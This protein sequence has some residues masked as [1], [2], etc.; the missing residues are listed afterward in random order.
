MAGRPARQP[1][2][3]VNFIPPVRDYEFGH[4]SNTLAGRSW[5]WWETC[6]PWYASTD[7]S[8]PCRLSS[9]PIVASP[10]RHVTSTCC[11][12]C[13]LPWEVEADPGGRPADPG[14]RV[15]TLQDPVVFLLRQSSHHPHITWL[16]RA[17]LVAKL[18]RQVEAD[19]GGRPADPGTRVP[20]LQDPV[21]V[22]LRQ[23]SHH[24]HITWL[25][26]AAIVAKPNHDQ[27]WFCRGVGCTL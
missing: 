8:G 9:P 26:R 2:A 4:L 1:Y 15:Q 20:T 24:P 12:S 11:L 22:L 10:W 3:I 17:N 16:P 7:P 14:T 27:S 5:S 13:Q 23:S 25:P 21:V 19:P 6:R 18:P